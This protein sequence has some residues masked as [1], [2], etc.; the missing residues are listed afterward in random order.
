MDGKEIRRRRKL[1]GMSQEALANALGVSRNTVAR[2]ENLKMRLE[3]EKLVEIALEYL[4]IT[5]K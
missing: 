4:G 3:H 1:L 5:G 2:W